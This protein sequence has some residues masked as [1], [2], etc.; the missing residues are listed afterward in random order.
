M[1][2]AYTQCDEWIEQVN[3]YLDENYEFLKKY[4][5]KNMP[6]LEVIPSEGTYMAWV[7]TEKLQISPE[8]LEKIFYRRCKGICLYGQQIWEAY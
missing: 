2:A 7:Q 6:E 1:E 5:E 8:E 4:L 3:A